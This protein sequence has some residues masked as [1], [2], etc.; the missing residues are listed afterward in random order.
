M[1]VFIVGLFDCLLGLLSELVQASFFLEVVSAG[2]VFGVVSLF[3]YA[4][5]GDK[6]A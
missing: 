1:S 6:R 5:R 3:H 4:I 2:V